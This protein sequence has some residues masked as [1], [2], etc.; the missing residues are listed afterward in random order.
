MSNP[1]FIY[2]VILLFNEDPVRN[3]MVIVRENQQHTC[4][5][6]GRVWYKVY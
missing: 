5:I 4:N 6:T 3:K 1:E 2:C